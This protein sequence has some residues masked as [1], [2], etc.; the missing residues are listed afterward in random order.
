MTKKKTSYWEA[1]PGYP[2][3]LINA[4]VILYI[5]ER[6]PR[7]QKEIFDFAKAEKLITTTAN[8]KVKVFEQSDDGS[9]RGV[10]VNSKKDV[11]DMRN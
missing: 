7:H 6:L 4:T 8:S 3:K 11:L 9:N 2:V 1:S 10:E 5:K